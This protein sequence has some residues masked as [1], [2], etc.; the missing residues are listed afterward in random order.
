LGGVDMDILGLSHLEQIGTDSDCVNSTKTFC[1]KDIPC[2]YA[3]WE[4]LSP[5]SGPNGIAFVNPG[6]PIVAHVQYKGNGRYHLS[7]SDNG[8]VLFSKDEQGSSD[9]SARNAADWIVEDPP[10]VTL[11]NYGT[12][13]FTGCSVDGKPITYG[14]TLVYTLLSSQQSNQLESVSGLN[15]I[16]NSFFVKWIQSQ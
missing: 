13:T 11:A 9:T 10:G 16:D 15:G 1:Q 4:T 6:D 7:I 12:V 3:W 14:P 8:K 5:D 2:Y